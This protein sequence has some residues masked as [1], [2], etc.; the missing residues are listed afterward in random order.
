MGSGGRVMGRSDCTVFDE[1][2]CV[3]RQLFLDPKTMSDVNFTK[4]VC[5][6]D[7]EE[8]GVVCKVPRGFVHLPSVDFLRA[9]DE[10]LV[11]DFYCKC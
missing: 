11:G 9:Y 7:V 4:C 1:G 8:N 3:A 10:G 2:V 6:A 5:I